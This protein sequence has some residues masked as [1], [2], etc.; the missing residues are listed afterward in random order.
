MA[1]SSVLAVQGYTL[2]DFAKTPEDIAKTCA[3][4]KKIGYDAVQL[5]GWGKIE[6]P[7]LA[8]IFKNEGLT[9]CAS[10]IGFD[11]IYNETEKVAE[12]HH[13]IGCK[14]TAP[15]SMPGAWGGNT[16]GY[17]RSLEGYTKFAKDA[18]EASEKLSKLGITLSYHNHKFEFEKYPKEG[19]RRGQDILIEDS[20]K[21][22]NF[23]LDTFWVQA[24]GCDPAAYIRKC[25]G[26]IP[27][28]H[29]KD[30]TIRDDKQI[31]AEVGEGN[32]NWPA[33]L[34]AAK[35]AGVE[36]YIVEQ[37]SCER[38][39]FESVAISLRNLKAMGLK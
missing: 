25:K 34:Q 9:C 33:I 32:L 18:S 23:E 39:P 7:E 37:D 20:N 5:S 19:G 30:M 15:G 38:D 26:R 13:I 1:S 12:E 11:R 14:H 36:W 6:Y 24:G 31:M 10:H 27:L 28:L 3:R 21:F 8:K 22:L 29:L 2:R 17:G 4:I 16:M 35:E